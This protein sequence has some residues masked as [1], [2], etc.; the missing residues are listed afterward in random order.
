M[1]REQLEIRAHRNVED[2][3]S[4]RSAFGT[5]SILTEISGMAPTSCKGM[6]RN[7]E[8]TVL[9]AFLGYIFWR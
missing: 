7:V 1:M 3:M 6:R 8:P 9:S 4:S 2:F 5:I